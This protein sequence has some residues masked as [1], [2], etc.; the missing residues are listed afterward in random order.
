MIGSITASTISITITPMATMSSGSS[1]VASCMARRCTSA[2]SWLAA[3][4]SI[5]GS[6]PVCSPKRANMASR[7][8]KRFFCASALASGAPSRTITRA[9][10]ASA[11][12]AVLCRVSAAA[13]SARRMGT[14]APASMASVLPKRAAL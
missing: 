14:P 5:S 10:S 4:C 12:M 2:L 6:W 9:S 8:G 1:T 13:C 3:R 11:R 7:P